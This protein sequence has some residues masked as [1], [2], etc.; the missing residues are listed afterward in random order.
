M[1][2]RAIGAWAFAVMA[3][4]KTT[5]KPVVIRTYIKFSPGMSRQS[6]ITIRHLR[7]ADGLK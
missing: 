2:V 4:A 5:I 1:P 6:A 7:E 3:I